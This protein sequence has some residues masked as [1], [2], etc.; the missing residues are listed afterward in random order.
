[1]SKRLSRCWN[2]GCRGHDA[3][4]CPCFVTPRSLSR[5]VCCCASCRVSHRVFCV[6]RV[7]CRVSCRTSRFCP[8]SCLASCHLLPSP[9]RENVTESTGV[10]ASDSMDGRNA[11]GIMNVSV[12]ARLHAPEPVKHQRFCAA[13]PLLRPCVERTRPPARDGV[14]VSVE[15]CGRSGSPKP[16][17]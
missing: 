3:R 6:A 1:M 8:M 13:I 17:A 12:E 11:P 4:N 9:V 10:G 16:G 15:R 5:H 2:D 7:L 14:R